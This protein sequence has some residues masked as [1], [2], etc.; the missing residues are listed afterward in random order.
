MNVV[1]SAVL[2]LLGLLWLVPM[3]TLMMLLGLFLHPRRTD[4][5]SRLY[6]RGQV[7]AT[8]SRWRA[9]VHPDV[10][11]ATPYFFA[12]NHVNLLDHVTM[13]PATPHF[14]QGI[15]LRE[16]FRIPVYGW[17]M[18]ARGTIAVDRGASGARALT[19]AVAAEVAKGHSLLGF[20]EGTR[21]L[22]GRVGRFRKGLF[23]VARDAGLPVVPVAVVGMFDVLRKG[24]LHLRPG[25]VTVHV[26]APIPTAG[27]ADAELDVLAERVRAQIA[28]LVEGT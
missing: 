5:V 4:A 11:P 6:C 16:H 27:L 13:Y 3:M 1:R 24:S 28:A 21:T 15:E 25:D 22:D 8:G 19:E 26:L 17:F 9:V 10:N 7:C 14:K 2:W 20:P 23:R 12:Q 18:R